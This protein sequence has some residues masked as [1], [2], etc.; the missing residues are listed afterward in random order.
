MDDIEL[1]NA[2]KNVPRFSLK[3]ITVAAKCVAVYDGDTAQFV[4]R[5]APGQPLYRYSCR[6]T[7]YNSAEIKGKT[8]E[9]CAAAKIARDALRD[10]ILNRIVQ[11]QIGDFD[12]YG[13][14][15]VTVTLGYV[16]INSWM[17]I[18][19]YGVEY[20]GTGAKKW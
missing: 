16:N 15:L 19:G 7:G 5:L 11:L 1:L 14:P 6:M 17:I 8:A 4:F 12:K 13:R 3:G 18:G 2:D 10:Q 20:D 9:E